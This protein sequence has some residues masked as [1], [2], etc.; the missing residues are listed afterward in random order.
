[1][2]FGLWTPTT[3]G[4]GYLN[5][6]SSPGLFGW[7]SHS[8]TGAPLFVQAS[9]N[10]VAANNLALQNGSQAFGAGVNLTALNLPGLN[11]DCLGNLR[12]TNGNWTMGAY[13]L[14]GAATISV[15]PATQAYGP[16]AIGATSDLTFTVQN[17]GSN[18]LTGSASTTAPFSI[19]S[20]GSFK[21]PAGQS[22]SVTVRFTPTAVGST[23]SFVMFPGGGIGAVTG[24]GYVGSGT[25]VPSGPAY[26]GGVYNPAAD[27]TIVE[28]LKADAITGYSDGQNVTTWT[29]SAGQDGTALSSGPVYHTNQENGLPTLTFNTTAHTLRTAAFGV[30]SQPSTIWVVYKLNAVAN[31]NYQFVFDGID[32]V[33]RSVL[34]C[35]TSA[36]FNAYA[37]NDLMCGGADANWRIA[38]IQFN[39]SSSLVKFNGSVSASGPAGGNNLTGLTIGSSWENSYSGNCQIGEIIVQN[40]LPPNDSYIFTYFNNKWAVYTPP[41]TAPTNLHVVS[42]GP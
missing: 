21:L 11:A 40:S 38:E 25:N 20:A 9:T 42:S 22:Q 16:V 7:D 18:M 3:G 12:P 10:N 35:N 13:Q 33:N 31:N 14:A 36:N 8:L 15:T 17:T 6:N 29:H 28:W 5:T 34:Y 30:L 37:A 41:L 26:V 24:S 27:S 19:V 32:N 2:V 39:G 1:M 4:G 23:N